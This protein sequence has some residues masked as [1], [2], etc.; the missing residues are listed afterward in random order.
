MQNPPIQSMGLNKNSHTP[1]ISISPVGNLLQQQATNPQ[2]NLDNAKALNSNVAALL[3][4][5]QFGSNVLHGGDNAIKEKINA[6]F[7]QTKKEEE[8]RRKLEE[9]Q[10]LKVVDLVYYTNRFF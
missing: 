2:L 7:E 1:P 9:E 10:H 6:L 4:H 5:H 8:R 3:A